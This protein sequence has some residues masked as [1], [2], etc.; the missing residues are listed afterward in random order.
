M[1]LPVGTISHLRREEHLNLNKKNLNQTR[2]GESLFKFIDLSFLWLFRNLG[3]QCWLIRRR[4]SLLFLAGSLLC[5]N[6]FAAVFGQA[7]LALEGY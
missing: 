4:V 3:C 5:F 7:L 6:F 1:R 2:L